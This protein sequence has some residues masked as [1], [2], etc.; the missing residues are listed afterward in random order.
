MPELTDGTERA[1]SVFFRLGGFPFM[2]YGLSAGGCPTQ[3]GPKTKLVYRDGDFQ[4]HGRILSKNAIQST[5]AVLSCMSSAATI[6]KIG[7][8]L[9]LLCIPQFVLL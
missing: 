9:D 1:P 8:H 3:Y 5:A 6:K 7:T 4:N 2:M